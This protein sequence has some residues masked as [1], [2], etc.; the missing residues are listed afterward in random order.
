MHQALQVIARPNGRF[1][2]W[3]IQSEPREQLHRGWL[4]HR[5]RRA[6]ILGGKRTPQTNMEGKRHAPQPATAPRRSLGT[7]GVF[8]VPDL[9][10]SLNPTDEHGAPMPWSDILKAG[11]RD[12]VAGSVVTALEALRTQ[13]LAALHATRRIHGD[14]TIGEAERH[15]RAAKASAEIILPAQ[16]PVEKAIAEPG[17]RLTS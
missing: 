10:P 17:N 2:Y 6:S 11:P 8:F 14:Q 16:P 7:S 15:R 5:R 4:L 1:R 13:G 12:K 9:S 3:W